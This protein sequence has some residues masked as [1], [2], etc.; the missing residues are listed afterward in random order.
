MLRG[1]LTFIGILI[2]VA[3]QVGELLGVPV[4]A[5]ELVTLLGG[6]IGYIGRAR[7]STPI[8]QNKNTTLQNYQNYPPRSG[9]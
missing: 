9:K 5:D 1:W 4:P 2:A 6:L 8:F 7:A 3:P